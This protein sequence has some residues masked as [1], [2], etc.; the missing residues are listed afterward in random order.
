MTP[1]PIQS[2]SKF[3]TFGSKYRYSGRTHYETK[4]APIDRPA[5]DFERTLSG[6]RLSSRSMD[7]KFLFFLFLLFKK[8][9]VYVLLLLIRSENFVLALGYS[10]N[11]AYDLQNDEPSKRHT[12]SHPPVSG[13]GSDKKTRK[14]WK[15]KYL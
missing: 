5:P 1:E 12:M 4:K 13:S 11:D 2:R 14:N 10:K 7:S 6:R 9:K 3:P 15:V 8:S